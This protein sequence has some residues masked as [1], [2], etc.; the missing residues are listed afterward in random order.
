MGYHIRTQGKRTLAVW[1]CK[2]VIH[3]QP[4]AVLVGGLCHS[5]QV[6]HQHGGIRR[7]FGVRQDGLRVGAESLFPA[8]CRGVLYP[9]HLDAGSRR[10]FIQKVES[11]AVNRFLGQ[12]G[13]S[14]PDPRQDC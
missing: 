7:R 8:R 3:H 9:N 6:D 11:T 4:S 1:G 12:E 10:N 5:R 2:G 14:S 13:L